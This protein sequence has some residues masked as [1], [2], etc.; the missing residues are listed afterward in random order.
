MKNKIISTAIIFVMLFTMVSI[1]ASAFS[2]GLD[3]FKKVNTYG[4]NQFED[5]KNDAWYKDTVKAVYEYDLMT[6][7]SESKF[8]PSG[9]TTIAQAITI[10]VRLNIIYYTGETDIENTGPYWYSG[11]VE[12]ALN[13]RII[14]KEYSNYNKHATR[15][16]FVTILA[17]A[18]PSEALDQKNTVPSGSIPDVPLSAAYSSAAY[19]LYRAGILSGNDSKGTF[20]PN[21]SI[22]RSEVSAIT[23]RMADTSLRKNFNLVVPPTPTP[24]PKPTVVP[25]PTPKP[26]TST[27]Y[28]TPSGTKYHRST[29]PTIGNSKNIKSG[30]VSQSGNRTACKVCKP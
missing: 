16:E 27:V 19:T 5:V 15:A 21:S 2:S 12:Y 8:S 7:T 3:N 1:P 30:T 6:G 26:V 14:L 9:N 24:T 18:L 4:Q 11:Y 22:R 13:N 25:T 20:T 28:W 10:A 17:K 29:C 23:S